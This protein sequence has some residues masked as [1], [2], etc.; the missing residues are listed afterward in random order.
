MNFLVR[1]F[2]VPQWYLH[3][4]LDA[5]R[6]QSTVP[7]LDLIPDLIPLLGGRSEPRVTLRPLRPVNCFKEDHLYALTFG[8][9][10]IYAV[11][12]NSSEKLIK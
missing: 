12:K 9:Y 8:T 11:E 1:N 5:G 4:F 7:Y 2:Y 6:K 3:R 10:A